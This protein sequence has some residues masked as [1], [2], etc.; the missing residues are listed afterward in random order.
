VTPYLVHIGYVLQLAALLS[1]DILWLRSLLI[2]AQTTLATYAWLMGVR[3]IAA[4]NAVLVSINI[5]WVI[6]ILRARR[7]VKLPPEL[8]RLHEQHFAALSAPEFLRLWRKGREETLATGAVLTRRDQYPERL[9]FLLSGR[10]TINRRDA[11]PAALHHGHFVG[12]MSLLTGEPATADVA[13]DEP[14]RA[15]VWPARELRAIRVSDPRL[16]TKIQS[17]IGHD[18]VEKIKGSTPTA[19][20]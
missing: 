6:V 19:H 5:I 7:D 11:P 16:W 14:A 18:L 13:A 15:M 8:A 9:F 17:V 12:E 2:V 4:W 10:V 20:P 3:P 1:R